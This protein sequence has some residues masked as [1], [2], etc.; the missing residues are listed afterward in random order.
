MGKIGLFLKNIFKFKTLE[1]KLFEELSNP[2]FFNEKKFSN[3]LEKNASKININHQDEN[4]NT[5]LHLS[6]GKSFFRKSL[7]SYLIENGAKT[8][9]I[10]KNGETPLFKNIHLLTVKDLSFIQNTDSKIMNFVYPNG[11]TIF[12][13]LFQKTPFIDSKIIQGLIDNGANLNTPNKTGHTPL[14][15]TVFH[16][17]RFNP[18]IFFDLIEKGARFSK[19]DLSDFDLLKQISL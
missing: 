7:A 15:Y 18:S 1:E 3:L 19:T 4:G 13:K 17:V 2:I 12:T 9:I 5:L 6:G 16:K 11:E 14:Y 10:N 8:D